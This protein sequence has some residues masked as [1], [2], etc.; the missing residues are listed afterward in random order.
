MLPDNSKVKEKE[1]GELKHLTESDKKH[2]K[3]SLEHNKELMEG[4]SKL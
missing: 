3:D 2:F 1:L 4:L